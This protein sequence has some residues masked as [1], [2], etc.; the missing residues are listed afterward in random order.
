MGAARRRPIPMPQAGLS[1]SEGS[2][3]T[4]GPTMY[5]RIGR[6]PGLSASRWYVVTEEA[7]VYSPLDAR[8]TV[9]ATCLQD[10]PADAPPDAR[11]RRVNH[12]RHVV[13]LHVPS[14]RRRACGDHATSR[15]SARNERQA[16]AL[17]RR[18]D[19]AARAESSSLGSSPRRDRHRARDHRSAAA[20][21]GRVTRS[22]PHR[23]SLPALGRSTT[24]STV[25]VK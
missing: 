7:A 2:G 1:E 23:V 25:F 21:R 20:G 6:S 8:S 11:T 13:S 17:R 19:A 24:R 16:G 5:P 9:R 18:A 22:L 3:I 14:R 10:L 15:P 4:V 12:P